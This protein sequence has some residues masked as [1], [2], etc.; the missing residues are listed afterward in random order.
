MTPD[1]NEN[2]NMFAL[3]EV[4]EIIIDDW[5][6]FKTMHKGSKKLIVLK[7]DFM[8]VWVILR[9][10]LRWSSWKWAKKRKLTLEKPKIA[11]K[12]PTIG[13]IE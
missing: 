2:P 10:V 4:H 3:K 1:T 5:H 7:L 9:L 12:R 8:F 6:E 13:I 11:K